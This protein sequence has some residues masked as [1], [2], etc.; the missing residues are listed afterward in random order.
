M[1]WV[2]THTSWKWFFFKF[3]FTIQTLLYFLKPIF[4]CRVSNWGFLKPWSVVCKCKKKKFHSIPYLYTKSEEWH[5]KGTC[6]KVVIVTC[7]H[8]TCCIWIW[9]YMKYYKFDS[10][11]DLNGESELSK[12][13]ICTPKH[14]S[15]ITFLPFT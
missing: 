7:H 6:N 9:S 5:V 11:Y 2:N 1:E 13:G 8:Y 14:A 10:I 12:L 15:I 3:I 4:A